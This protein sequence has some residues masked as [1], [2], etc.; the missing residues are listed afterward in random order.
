MWHIRRHRTFRPVIISHFPFKQLFK[1]R[2][3]LVVLTLVFAIVCVVA[4]DQDLTQGKSHNGYKRARPLDR[5]HV[6]PGVPDQAWIKDKEWMTQDRSYN[7]WETVDGDNKEVDPK[8]R[9]GLRAGRRDRERKQGE[10]DLEPQ[11]K[12]PQA[13]RGKDSIRG[14]GGEERLNELRR[15][16]GVTLT[17]PARQKYSENKAQQQ[18][19]KKEDRR[20]NRGST[21]KQANREK[22]HRGRGGSRSF[23]GDRPSEDDSKPRGSPRGSTQLKKNAGKGKEDGKKDNLKGNSKLFQKLPKKDGSRFGRRSEDQKKAG[24]Q[25]Q[26]GSA[27]KSRQQVVN[28]SQFLP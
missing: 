22:G 16:E 5:P 3:L 18:L 15:G 20:P 2:V 26:E 19:G 25:D 17:R 14:E 4:V 10:G 23:R 24:K 12:P 28:S 21:T 9:S 8:D 13:R 27:S 7:K 11:I 6:D 1:M